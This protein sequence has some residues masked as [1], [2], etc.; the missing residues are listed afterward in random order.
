M[1]N[2]FIYPHSI[3]FMAGTELVSRDRKV[4]NNNNNQK[5]GK[6]DVVLTSRNLV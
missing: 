3:D 4:N 2:L 6:Q 5:K 1:L